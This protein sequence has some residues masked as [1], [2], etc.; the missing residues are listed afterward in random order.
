MLP[1]KVSSAEH[2]R[3][4]VVAPSEDRIN[5]LDTSIKSKV[6]QIVRVDFLMAVND[7]DFVADEEDKLSIFSLENG[8]DMVVVSAQAT[9][10]RTQ[11]DSL[12][13]AAH[14]GIA[15]STRL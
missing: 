4:V 2:I 11:L 13:T 15:T 6:S 14:L 10:C 1:P 12:A 3:S 7:D 8:I 9:F 5:L